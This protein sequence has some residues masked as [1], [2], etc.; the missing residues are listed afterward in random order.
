M[1]VGGGRLQEAAGGDTTEMKNWEL[2]P[3][4]APCTTRSSS[5]S[6]PS[7]WTTHG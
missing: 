5:A 1:A 7:S 3:G 2:T 4:S 6:R